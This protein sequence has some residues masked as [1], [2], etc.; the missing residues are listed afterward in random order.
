MPN[1]LKMVN[2]FV[3][4]YPGGVY[5][6]RLA[7]H[8]KVVEEHLNE[9]EVVNYAFVAQKNNSLFDVFSTCV[10]CVTD[11]R[12]VMG[13]KRLLFGYS[14]STVTPDMFND[15]QIYSGI[16]FGKITVDTIKETIYFTNVSK[17][18]LVEIESEISTFML[19]EK[20]N[21]D[22]ERND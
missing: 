12:I 10:V 15:M 19:E 9:D 14:F 11:K 7:K 18:A 3:R 6:F 4:K 16:V 21:D 20:N 5:W 1:V 13:Q 22:E 17:K 8:S 2:D